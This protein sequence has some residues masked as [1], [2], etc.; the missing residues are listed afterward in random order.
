MHPVRLLYKYSKKNRLMVGKGPTR[1]HAVSGEGTRKSVSDRFHL[2]I[3]P[4]HS[5]P[6][7]PLSA[8]EERKV[9]KRRSVDLSEILRQREMRCENRKTT[10]KSIKGIIKNSNCTVIGDCY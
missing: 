8:A 9:S 1:G 6:C 7:S 3:V 2:H 10:R 4:K 5:L